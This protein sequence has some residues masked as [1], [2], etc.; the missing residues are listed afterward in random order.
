MARSGENCNS[1][2]FNG[3]WYPPQDPCLCVLSVLFH[4]DCQDLNDPKLPKSFLNKLRI[5]GMKDQTWRGGWPESAE[6]FWQL[7]KDAYTEFENILV[8]ILSNEKLMAIEL[9]PWWISLCIRIAQDCIYNREY[10]HALSTAVKNR[11][12]TSEYLDMP[13]LAA[14]L[15]EINSLHTV[16]V[17]EKKKLQKGQIDQADEPEETV[18]DEVE[19]EDS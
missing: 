17:K 6:R 8:S 19:E 2:K 10:W 18:E 9:Y 3:S 15:E 5:D 4:C 11:R 12:A 14:E 7:V 1:G 16:E 13:A